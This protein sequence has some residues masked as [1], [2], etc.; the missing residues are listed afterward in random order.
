MD[1]F[2]VETGIPVRVI[3]A[4]ES[5]TEGLK[6]EAALLKSR[7]AAVD[8]FQIDTIWLGTVAKYLLDLKLALSASISEEMPEAISSATSGGRVIAVPYFLEYGVLYYRADLLKRYG[9]ARPPRTWDELERQASRIQAGQRKNGN[10]DFWGYVWQGA[11]YEGL[12]CNALEW[13]AS[14]GGGTLL[15]ENRTVEVDNPA[16][17]RAFSSA[18][19]WIGTISPRGVLAYNEEDSRNVFQSGRA[20]FLRSWSYV[21]RLAKSSPNIGDRFGVAPIP[22]GVDT[23]SSTLGGWYLGISNNSKHRDEAI[24]FVKYMTGK[25]AQ[26]ER[27]IRGALLP[28][29]ASLYHDPAVLAANPFFASTSGPADRFI[30]RPALLADGKYEAVSRAYAHGVHMILSGEVDAATGAAT[31]ERQIMSV[32]G[33]AKGTAAEPSGDRRAE[34]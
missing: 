9:F 23:H 14:R 15:G 19:H 28:S 25:R 33:F 3:P 16:A 4:S 5:T 2:T 32:T 24:A 20:A 31:M 6:Q 30:A 7:S 27:A 12:T 18:A 13:Q 22:V 8:V 21:Y 17:V 1:E 26:R 34:R 10:D 29:I 11:D